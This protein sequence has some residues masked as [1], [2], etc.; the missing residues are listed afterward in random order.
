MAL[1]VLLDQKPRTKHLAAHLTAERLH[2]V[3]HEFRVGLEV[4]ELQ[5]LV[6]DL[7]LHHLLVEVRVLALPVPCNSSAA[8]YRSYSHNG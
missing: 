4:L 5:L 3:V 8:S 7:A 6:T 2:L 1:H